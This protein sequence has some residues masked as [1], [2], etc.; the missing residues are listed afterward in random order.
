MS[1]WNPSPRHDHDAPV[2]YGDAALPAMSQMRLEVDDVRATPGRVV[3][4]AVD[5]APVGA[6]EALMICTCGAEGRVYKSRRLS[7][8]T[9]RRYYRCSK[10]PLTL[11]TT[12][13]ADGTWHPVRMPLDRG[14]R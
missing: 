2:G 13:W 3:Q 7:G 11:S 12:E 4:A 8:T 5:R 10:C 6:G 14:E 1:V 9:K